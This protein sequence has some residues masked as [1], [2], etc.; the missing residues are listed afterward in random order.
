[1]L[2][3]LFSL[4]SF[5]AIFSKLI[6]FGKQRF[7]KVVSSLFLHNRESIVLL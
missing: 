4:E 2:Q 7:S 1:M 6:L 5:G 3:W